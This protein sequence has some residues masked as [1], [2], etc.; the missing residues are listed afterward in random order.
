MFLPWLLTKVVQIGQSALEYRCHFF[1]KR[2]FISGW[3][4]PQLYRIP[5]KVCCLHNMSL[6]GL[7]WRQQNE[8]GLG[9]KNMS[10]SYLEELNNSSKVELWLKKPFD[11]CVVSW[12]SVLFAEQDTEIWNHL[13]AVMNWLLGAWQLVEAPGASRSYWECITVNN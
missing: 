12:L 8:E 10:T 2:F 9:I 3:F 11:S 5:L 1:P 4:T 6:S 13:G 7:C